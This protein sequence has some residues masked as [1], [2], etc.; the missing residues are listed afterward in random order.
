MTV[1][2]LAA[3]LGAFVGS[4]TGFGFALVLSPVLFAVL[5][6]LEAVYTLLVLSLVLNTLVLFEGGGRPEVDWRRLVPLL[7]A[8]LPGL[9][10]GA[11]LLVLL[12]RE[13][14]QV[15]V[16]VAVI[17]AALWQLR[18]R[19]TGAVRTRVLGRAASLAVG[20]TSGVLTTS[21]SVS[22]PPIVL[23]LE[24]H[25]VPPAEFRAT[26]AA[27]FLILSVAGGAVLLAAEGG[28]GLEL[29]VIA[30]LLALVVAGYFLG[31][32][33]FRRLD[34]QRFFIIALSLVVVT[35]AGS[36]LAGLGVL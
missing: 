22:G 27:S 23:W 20:F 26:L 12:A 34:H 18:S 28:G 21:L 9:A 5:E 31:A 33:A 3:L 17:A 2:A 19:V 30:P 24:A 15:S 10:A 14:L 25:R 29:D 16:G 1:A 11:A 32:L 35:G 36:V 8:A 7:L 4:A 6:P 13:T